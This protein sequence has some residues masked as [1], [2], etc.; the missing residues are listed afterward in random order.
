MDSRRAIHGPSG[1]MSGTRERAWFAHRRSQA[2]TTKTLLNQTVLVGAV[3]GGALTAAIRREPAARNYELAPADAGYPALRAQRHA[4]GALTIIGNIGRR[5]RR[6]ADANDHSHD[7][8]PDEIAPCCPHQFML[9]PFGEGNRP[10]SVG[11]RPRFQYSRI[12][13]C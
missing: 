8:N 11:R 13:F 5:G 7:R 12:R 1:L 9:S 6:A 10:A 4:L 2:A 3:L